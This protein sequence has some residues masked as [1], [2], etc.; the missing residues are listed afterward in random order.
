M[1]FLVVIFGISVIIINSIFLFNPLTYE[2][3]FITSQD[4]S[5]Y[6]T[7]VEV[8]Y[9]YWNDD[10]GWT[11]VSSIEESAEAKF[12]IAEL[13]ESKEI[14]YTSQEYLL[15]DNMRG[16]EYKVIIR[17]RSGEKEYTNLAQFDFFENGDIIDFD[18]V[19]YIKST[20]KLR[21]LLWDRFS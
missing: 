20:H 17:R 8:V 1:F 3:D 12:I 4:C 15:P 19:N 13:K 16:E 7:P 11:I 2:E 18:G 5:K 21:Q 10:G 9:Y 6:R 14:K